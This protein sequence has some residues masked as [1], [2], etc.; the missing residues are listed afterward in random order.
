MSTNLTTTNDARGELI[1]VLQSSLY[2]GADPASVELVIG[3]CATA[4]LDV[5]QKPVHI[6]PVW[7]G[8]AGR[9][10]DVIMPGIGLYR[11]QASRTGQ[12]LGTSEPEYGPMVTERIGG[13]DVTYPEWCRVTVRRLLP[14]GAVAEF[15]AL[16][17][18][19][20]N[21]AVKGGKEKS[22]APNAMWSRR[23]RG[24][25]AK[26]AEAQALRRAFPELCSALTAEEM[27]GKAIGDDPAPAQAPRHMGDIKRV[28]T[29]AEPSAELRSMAE[30]ASRLG[31]AAYGAFWGSTCTRADR[32]ALAGLH[33]DLKRA[34]E[35]ADAASLSTP[36]AEQIDA[37]TSEVAA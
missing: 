8:K 11:T 2:P 35:E 9:M 26:C 4:G 34:A 31:V 24:Q 25:I 37:E 6:V 21:Y 22:V 33:A 19:I 3:Y 20:E 29:P 32:Q 17:Y 28:D 23:V 12:H 5:M 36:V 30:K 13:Q 7:D 18:W 27:E 1:Q 16:E 15:S 10:R 14:G